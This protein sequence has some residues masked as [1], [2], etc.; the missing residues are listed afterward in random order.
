M[1]HYSFKTI[2]MIFHF[3]LLYN[4]PFLP[5]PSVSV[6]Y[7]SCPQAIEAGIWWPRTKFGLPAA[8]PCPKGTLGMMAFQQL[9]KLPYNN[10]NIWNLPQALSHQQS[11]PHLSDDYCLSL[12]LFRHS[13]PTLWW[14]QGLV[15]SQSLQLYLCYLQQAEN[16]GVCLLTPSVS[17]KRNSEISKNIIVTKEVWR[18]GL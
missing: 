1:F 3:H 15:A 17:F 5:A 18:L 2:K 13:N 6:I 14:A 10:G 7:D 11:T 12:L 9:I 8:V 4:L 16:P